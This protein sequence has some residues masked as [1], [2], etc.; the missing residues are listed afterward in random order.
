MREN[1]PSGSVEGAAGDRGPYSDPSASDQLRPQ[2]SHP[3]PTSGGGPTVKSRGNVA[4]ALPENRVNSNRRS[5]NHH[6]R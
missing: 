5:H 2:R 6:N 1:R 4:A 3:A